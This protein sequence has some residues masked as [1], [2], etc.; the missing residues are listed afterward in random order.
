MATIFVARSQALQKWGASVGLTKHLY[1]LGIAADS[2]DEA[3]A[4]L[5]DSAHAGERDWRLVKKQAVDQA[6]E[7]A[8]IERLA[9]KE[10]MV[11]PAY[12]P[13]IKGARG[14]FKVKLANVE[15]HFLVKR[16]MAGDEEIAV[17]ITPAEIAAYLMANAL[18]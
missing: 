6:D 1:K 11:D 3:V 16:A 7:D 4:A 14:I 10:T 12:Y 9:R 8:A 2:A 17:K 18:G 15:N 13:K 5:N